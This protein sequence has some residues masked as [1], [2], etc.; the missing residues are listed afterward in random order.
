MGYSFRLLPYGVQDKAQSALQQRSEQ[1]GLLLSCWGTQSFQNPFMKEYTLKF[2][3]S[4]I[5]FKVSSFTKGYWSVWVV[6]THHSQNSEVLPSAQSL[7]I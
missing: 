2:V 3:G 5:W 4:L 6:E 7:Q 1:E